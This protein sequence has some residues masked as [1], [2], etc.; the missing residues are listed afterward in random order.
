[1][2]VWYVQDSLRP[3]T[4]RFNHYSTS[5]GN[6]CTG[7]HIRVRLGW[8]LALFFPNCIC[9]CACIIVCACT[10]PLP[11]TLRTHAHQ[12]TRYNRLSPMVCVI[13]C[14][15]I[16]FPSTS[17]SLV[18]PDSY[19][20]PDCVTILHKQP[21]FLTIIPQELR[22]AGI[23]LCVWSRII[24]TVKLYLQKNR[25]IHFEEYV[26]ANTRDLIY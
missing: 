4:R 13:E 10:W 16:D 26:C 24:R 5:L 23:Y 8:T 3:A 12:S 19:G 22:E 2:Q 15:T 7:H 20:A 18:R 21:G 17:G 11:A 14:Y 6:N 1:V 25:N 9:V